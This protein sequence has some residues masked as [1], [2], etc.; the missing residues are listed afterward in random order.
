MPDYLVL[1]DCS[2]LHPA[3]FRFR[4]RDLPHP[5]FPHY[6]ERK[7]HERY[8]IIGDG[9][10]RLPEFTL[11]VSIY[12]L[13]GSVIFS[14]SVRPGDRGFVQFHI[15]G[16]NGITHSRFELPV[17]EELPPLRSYDVVVEVLTPSPNPDD[18]AHLEATYLR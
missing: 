9:E 8:I 3:V 18:V 14:H 5:I 2:L 7:T 1:P 6:L 10:R 16:K 11:R 15:E 17:P 13:N 12:Q 4:V